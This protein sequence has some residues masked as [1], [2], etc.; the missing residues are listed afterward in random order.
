MLL[1]HGANVNAED[2]DGCTPLH[3]ASTEAIVQALLQHGADCT[4][5]NHLGRTALHETSNPDGLP[6]WFAKS[7]SE[8]AT[9]LLEY[10]ANMD[11]EDCEGN[12]PLDLALNRK[13]EKVIHLLRKNGAHASKVRLRLSYLN[14]H[15]SNRFCGMK[16]HSEQA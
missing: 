6:S 7:T 3:L 16:P 9:L 8:I 15:L 1:E 4:A 2:K 10:G 12:T 5:V 14:S 13:D 11:A